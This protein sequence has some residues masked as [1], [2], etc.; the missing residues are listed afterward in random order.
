MNEYSLIIPEGFSQLNYFEK[1]YSNISN[2]LRT[3]TLTNQRVNN[4]LTEFDSSM[5]SARIT[6]LKLSALI[7]GRS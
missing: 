3:T 6:L 7:E 4:R 5:G 2:H 1:F